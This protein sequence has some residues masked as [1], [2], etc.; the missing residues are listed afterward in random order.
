M[1]DP[2]DTAL[3]DNSR[4]ENR[5]RILQ[6]MLRSIGE[7]ENDPAL[8]TTLNGQFDEGTRAAVRAFQ[9]KYGLPETGTVQLATWDKISD[10]YRELFLR[11]GVPAG[12]RPFLSDTQNI[13]RGERSTLV[14]ILQI[15]LDT[16][17]LEFD[18]LSYVPLSGMYD[19]ATENAVREFQRASLL[20][21]TGE[22]NLPTW[23]RLA[24]AYNRTAAENQ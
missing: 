8:F 18:Q 10:I 17:R 23:N 20:D 24:A 22:V 12:I 9:K 13:S 19:E 15:M 14:L 1:I 11:S 7:D 5:I 3:Y 21:A 2:L 16:L 6:Q 4:P